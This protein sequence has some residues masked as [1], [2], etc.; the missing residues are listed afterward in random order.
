MVYVNTSFRFDA[1]QGTW[2]LAYVWCY[3]TTSSREV[4]ASG[5]N[6]TW[7][8]VIGH[9]SRNYLDSPASTATQTYSLR[10]GNYP[11]NGTF[12]ANLNTAHDGYSYIR[13]TEYAP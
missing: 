12:H 8:H 10:L 1:P 7:R 2:A 6:G 5:W 13:L 11:S 3:N 4:Y 9:Y